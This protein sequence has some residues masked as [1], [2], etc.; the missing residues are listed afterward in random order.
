MF[1]GWYKGTIKKFEEEIDAVEVEFEKEKG[2]K[3]IY[4]V[5]EEVTAGWIKLAK[6]T[7]RS[8]IPYEEIIEIGA[9][10]EVKWTKEE[11]ASTT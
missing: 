2:I 10:V 9:T 11:L 1:L 4:K 5:M 7:E 6:E 8:L 3:Y